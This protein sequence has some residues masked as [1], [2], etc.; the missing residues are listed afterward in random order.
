[1]KIKLSAVILAAGESLRMG[2]PKAL[3]KIGKNTFLEKIYNNLQLCNFNE[4]LCVL[5]KDSEQIK[6]DHSTLFMNYLINENHALGQI[7]SIQKGIESVKEDSEGVFLA[8]V[9]MPLVKIETMRSM[10]KVWEENKENI[11]IPTYDDHGGHP[12]IFPRKFFPN[13]LNAPMDEGARHVVY[14]NPDAVIRVPVSDPGVRKDFDYPGDLS[15]LE[16]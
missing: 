9:D 11:I 16:I 8:L 3:L 10:I 6:S 14:N 1:M 2:S 15:D 13:L 7:S 12:V 4:I 5:G